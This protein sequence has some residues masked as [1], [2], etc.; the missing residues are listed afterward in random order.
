M[1]ADQL[2]AGYNR[3]TRDYYRIME[4][5]YRAL[6]QPNAVATITGLISNVTHR[7]N[8]MPWK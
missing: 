2:Q 1:T 6:N 7:L 8:C 3:F 5:V 4:I